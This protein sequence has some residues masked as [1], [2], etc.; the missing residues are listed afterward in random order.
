MGS[1]ASGQTG[2]SWTGPMAGRGPAIKQTRHDRVLGVDLQFAGGDEQAVAQAAPGLE[3]AL[4]LRL[5]RRPP[6]TPGLLESDLEAES[7]ELDRQ[8]QSTQAHHDLLERL[9]ADLIAGRGRLPEAAAVLTDLGRQRRP[10]WLRGVR[11]VY[12][13][14]SDEASVAASLVNYCLFRL[15]DRNPADED[16]TRRLAADYRAGYGVPLTL[17][18]PAKGAAIP[19]CWGVVSAGGGGR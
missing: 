15:R 4:L 18:E 17:P 10:G 1:S 9:S 8:L 14:R 16:T 19:P 3:A 5:A 12:P 6:G 13:A 2:F 11:Q 7:R